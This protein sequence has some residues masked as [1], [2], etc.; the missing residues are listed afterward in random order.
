MNKIILIS[1]FLLCS[2]SLFAQYWVVKGSV[3]DSTDQVPL[4]AATVALKNLS[5][6]TFKAKATDQTGSFRLTGVENGL[7][8]LWDAETAV[9]KLSQLKADYPMLSDIHFWA[10]FPGESHE[11]GTRRMQYIADKVLPRLR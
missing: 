5:D 4:F 9:S 6:S 2:S 10:Q 11:S 7:Y 3:V 8:E 1:V